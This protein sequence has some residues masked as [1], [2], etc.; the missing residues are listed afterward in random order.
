MQFADFYI[1]LKYKIYK[2]AFRR[3]CEDAI[4][5]ILYGAHV[6]NR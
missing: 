5:D 2:I 3:L 6:T 4:L 1:A